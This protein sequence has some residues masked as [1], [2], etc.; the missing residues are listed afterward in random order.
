MTQ[1]DSSQVPGLYRR[2]VGDVLVTA[3]SDGYIDAA[4]EVLRGIDAAGAEAVLRE[5]FRPAPPR[6]SVNCYLLQCG[7]RTALV[8]TGSGDSMGPTLGR[9]HGLLARLG[10]S[11]GDVDTVLLTHM[12]P[13]H[14]NGLADAGGARL[15]PGAVLVVDERELAHWNDDAARSRADETARSRYFDAARAQVTPYRDGLASPAGEPFPNVTAVALPGH[16]P[17]HT[18]YLVASGG[19]SLLIW[20][21]ICHVPDIQVRQP[22]V[23]MVFDVDPQAAV[24]ARRR[25]FDM[26]ASD[27]ILVAGM[28]LHFPGFCHVVRDGGGWRMIPE[29]WQFTV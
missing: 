21:D 2:R 19:D 15:F 1:H 14:S 27:R 9:L 16:T 12:H 8:D 23:T 29:A 20:G 10:I 6:I 4:F 5:S 25:A 28:H 18:G 22:E 26:T 7:T 13:D 11:A 17:G 3:I 24:Q